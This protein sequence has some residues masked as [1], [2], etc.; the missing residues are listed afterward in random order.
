MLLCGRGIQE[1]AISSGSDVLWV[2][3]VFWVRWSFGLGWFLLGLIVRLIGDVNYFL[4][5]VRLLLR[6]LATRGCANSFEVLFVR[7]AGV[8][9]RGTLGV[10]Q[11]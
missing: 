8:Q 4:S 10:C 7:H 1:R 5:F 11:E 2:F 6:T 9:L 3:W